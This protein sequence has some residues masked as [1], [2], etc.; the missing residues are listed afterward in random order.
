MPLEE[1]HR[2][3]ILEAGADGQVISFEE[4]PEK[5]RGTLGSMG[6]YVFDRDT[7]IQVLIEDARA[8]EVGGHRTQH[9]FG[10]NIIPSMMAQGRRVYA[11]P[12]T[13]YWQDVGPFSRIGKLIWRCLKISLPSIS[14]IHLG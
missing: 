6:I 8:T 12:F 14:T 10:H 9:D 13:G 4:K 3:G 1:G 5:P 2:F 11:Y 7:L